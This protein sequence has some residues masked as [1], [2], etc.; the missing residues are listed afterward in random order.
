MLVPFSLHSL[1]AFAVLSHAIFM[2]EQL[3]QKIRTVLQPSQF[4]DIQE[5]TVALENVTEGT[6][7]RKTLFSFSSSP[8]L[9][10]SSIED[11]ELRHS[12]VKMFFMSGTRSATTRTH[13][14]I[15]STSSSVITCK[16]KCN[17]IQGKLLT[18]SLPSSQLWRH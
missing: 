9:L 14:E 2:P 17:L 10:A 18:L 13:S 1:Q 16:K 12:T 15:R 7:Y 5:V 3:M 4:L 6:N 8:R 11:K